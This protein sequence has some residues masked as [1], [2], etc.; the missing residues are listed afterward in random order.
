MNHNESAAYAAMMDLGCKRLA[1][2]LF[3]HLNVLTASTKA[4]SRNYQANSLS[5]ATY[6]FLLR[7]SRRP[8]TP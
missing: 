6:S 3:L 1:F 8:A 2:D 5:Y 7:D 4:L